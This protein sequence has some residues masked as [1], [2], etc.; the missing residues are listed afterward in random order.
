MSKVDTK[1][2]HIECHYPEFNKIIDSCRDKILEKFPQ[3]GNTWE[4]CY[5]S[6]F[7]RG[8]LETEI[9]EI[10]R[11]E[12]PLEM[13]REIVDVINVLVMMYHNVDGMYN[14]SRM[15]FGR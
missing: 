5:D 11:S 14:K 13:K 3:Y 12:R 15:E 7:W 6:K 8:R 2:P 1:D 9:K 10:W 4:M